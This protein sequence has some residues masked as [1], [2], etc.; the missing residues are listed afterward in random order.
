MDN[1]DVI[2]FYVIVVSF[3]LLNNL[4][5]SV[6]RGTDGFKVN[7]QSHLLP[8]LATSIKVILEL[9]EFIYFVFVCCFIY[10]N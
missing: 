3:L 6:N 9:H 8:V 5:C 10:F 2:L 7:T 1:F 4:L